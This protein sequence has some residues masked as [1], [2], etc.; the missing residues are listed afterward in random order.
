ALVAH[1]E[2]L[3]CKTPVLAVFEDAHWADPTSLELVGR[4][5]ERLAHHR[6]LLV[7]TYRPEFAPPW[8]ERSHMTSLAIDR[9]ARDDAGAMIDR[10]VGSQ[11]LPADVRKDILERTDG[12]PLFVEEMTKAVLEA[13]SESGARR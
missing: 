11:V 13:N 12:I 7:V 8:I 3:A 9:L 5:V 6:V 1:I 10:V 2:T 4:I